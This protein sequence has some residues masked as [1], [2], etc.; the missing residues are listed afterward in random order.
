MCSSASVCITHKTY[1]MKPFIIITFY[2]LTALGTLYGQQQTQ[3]RLLDQKTCKPLDLAIIS[4][5]KDWLA[6]TDS[7]G[8]A[9]ATLTAGTHKILCSLVGYTKRDTS[10]TC[11]ST[12][13]IVISLEPEDATLNEVTIIASTR[14]QMAIENSPL[15]VEVIDAA[16][17]SEEASVK[18]GNIA[19][20]LG[21]VSG[22]QIQQSSATSGNSNVRIQGLGGRYTQILRDGMPLYDGFSGGFGILTV[23]PLDLKQI[24]LIKGSAST[25]YGGGAIAGLINLI[26][27][28]PIVEQQLDALINYSSL[29][30]ANVNVY[31]AKRSKKMGYT[32]FVGH[33]N[34]QAIDVNKDGLSDLAEANSTL[35]HPK[36]FFYPSSNT[37]LSIGYSGALDD[38]I[39]GDM[40]VLQNKEDSIH[41]Y[42]E[43]NI[44]QRHTGEYLLEHQLH[45]NTKL[46]LKG[47]W[48]RFG[49]NMSS[50]LIAINGEQ[51]SYYN[52][53]SLYRPSP[54][55]D[56]V[57]G[58]NLVGD[59]YNTKTPNSALLQNFSNQ[60]LGIFGQYSLKWKASTTLETGLRFDHHQRYGWFALP[61]IAVFHRFSEQW[62]A[63]AGFGMGYK[64]PNPLVQQNTEY[65]VLDL[66]PLNNTVQA[67]QSYG[68]NAECNYKTALGDHATIFIN[69]AFFATQINSPILFQNNS[70]GKIDLVNA[71][72]PI[73]S[74]GF[75][76]YVKLEVHSWEL[77][78]GYTL[79]DA[80][81]TYQTTN[82]RIPL[83]PQHRGA[84]ILVKEFG[85]KCRIGIEGSYTG[86]Q[87]R[88]DGTETPSYLFMAAM[89]QYN[90]GKH[91]FIVLNGEN[92]LDY[93]MSKVEALYTGSISQ[94]TF[95][96]LWA[97]IDGRVINLSLRWKL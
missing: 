75:D 93:R 62:A 66:L 42:F 95:K 89:A 83:T 18:P 10:I 41:T 24:E 63:R 92:L 9:S 45:N 32:L 29:Q 28:R 30:E 15:K 6:T 44:S 37:T 67:E 80:R 59:A 73:V 84:F 17:L 36:L 76:S 16:D 65:S 57:A 77:Y 71:T 20:I 82:A 49:R 97:P 23:P 4:T 78:L 51:T 54:K 39:G 27:K 34:Q 43:K 31:A 68:Y 46:T 50:N 90:V 74:K 26:S 86:S 70:L 58:V 72:K 22:V 38:R 91:F 2:I 33:T 56:L 11:P 48:S 14:T 12:D 79:T 64:T 19:S 81:N 3:F 96:P 52:E 7:L 87:W 25:L 47:N 60:T 55:A 53:A 13:T 5:S 85:E 8:R 88:Y 40:Q 94:P 21:D 69:Q 61:R 1:K 35:F